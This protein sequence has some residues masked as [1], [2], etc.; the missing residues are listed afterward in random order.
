MDEHYWKKK[1]NARQ[2]TPPLSPSPEQRDEEGPGLGDTFW[3]SEKTSDTEG[4]ISSGGGY[5]QQVLKGKKS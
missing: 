3:R 5:V 2:Q 1:I 4:T